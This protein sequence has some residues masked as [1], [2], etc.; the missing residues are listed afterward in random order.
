MMIRNANAIAPKQGLE[1]GGQFFLLVSFC[2]ASYAL[3]F[4]D[5]DLA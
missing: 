1:L 4:M 3:V 2:L 5:A